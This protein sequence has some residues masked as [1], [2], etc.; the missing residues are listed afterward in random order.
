M[1]EQVI[2]V[3][4]K[5]E[6][7]GAMAKLEVHQKGLLHRAFSVFVFNNAGQLLLQ[8]RAA[9]K[10]HSAMLWSNTC[11]SH[12]MPDEDSLDAARRRL[13]EEMGIDIMLEK[14]FDFIYRA[15]LDNGLTE[16]EFDHVYVGTFNG[17]PHLNPAEA[18]DY[19]WVTI[20]ELK[21]DIKLHPSLYTTWLKIAI[22]H[23]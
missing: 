13:K 18:S 17:E 15:D 9:N 3:N 5:D 16:H 14:K 7:I 22:K 20:N 21:A 23:F 1:N 8:C 12:P 19:K 2:L 4:E 10:Y 11:C 6:P